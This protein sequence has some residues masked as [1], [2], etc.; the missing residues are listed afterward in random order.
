METK[1]N[2]LVELIKYPV[3][4]FSIVLA[5]IL[6]KYS[7]NLEF[8]MITEVSTDGL[9]FSEKSNK[10]ALK[11]IA[12]LEL[13]LNDL[14]VRINSIEDRDSENGVDADQIEFKA[15]TASQ[16]VSDATAN[17]AQLSPPI[18]GKQSEALAG[19]MWIGNYTDEW[20]KTPL[21]HI[22]TGQPIKIA[23]TNMQ[24]GTEYKVL[25]NMVVRDGL[26]PND[27]DYYHA[28]KILGVVPRGS[29]VRLLKKP[30]SIDREFTI[31]YWAKAEYQI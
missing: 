6:L 27:E 11:A 30:E 31:Q 15:F 25:N 1:G 20:S 18:Q 14:S 13:R 23:L 4:V 28:R 16:E 2:H 10:E 7:L 19:W 26:P 24:V 17:I 21:A 8:G 29:R 9:K 5:L 22:D 12:G 3:L